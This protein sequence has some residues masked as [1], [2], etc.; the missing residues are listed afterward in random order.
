MSKPTD[1]SLPS[2][3]TQKVGSTITLQK[4]PDGAVTKR[5]VLPGGLRV[6]SEYVP[7]MRSV[8]VG[9]WV[10]VGS[11]DEETAVA[12]SAHFLEHL[13]FKGTSSKTALDLSSSIDR[14]GG[15][16]NAFTAKE[17]TCFYSRVLDQD[18][19]VAIETL[20]DMLV[21]STIDKK[22]FESERQVILEEIA[23]RDDDYADVAHEMLVQALYGSGD[24]A[25]PILGTR[26]TIM[27]SKRDI[28]WNFYKHHYKPRNIVVAAAGGVDHQELVRLVKRGF[29]GLLKGRQL[30]AK[31]RTLKFPG[32]I[33]HPTKITK[34]DSEQSHLVIGYPAF[35]R[36][37]KHRYELGVLNTIL[38]G[39]MSSRLFQEI[40][41]VRGLAYTTY[42]FT[43]SFSD[44]G[45]LGIY[46][47][48][49]PQKAQEVLAVVDEV[50]NSL[51]GTGPSEEE[52]FRS[53]GQLKG[54][55]VLG[56]EDSSSRMNRIAKAELVTGELP[57]VDELIR[58]IESVTSAQVE[59]LARSIFSQKYAISLVGPYSS[60]QEFRQGKGRS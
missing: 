46:A 40:R 38:G 7:A 25:R 35:G 5:T 56:Q 44:T 58:R 15:E 51:A 50:T 48:F 10:N 4:S 18:L 27:K 6:I 32:T 13:L 47:G 41:E 42:A 53:K 19:K 16:M 23:M 21:N 39:G 29:Q 28:V 11:R 52:L 33:H 31:S 20:S 3:R 59:K 49:Q 9:M 22:D 43:Q 2:A 14:V 30:P 26:S 55:L 54:S 8:S 60:V 1:W 36:G 12:G 17:Y 37:N 24:I 45:Y 34:R 57:S